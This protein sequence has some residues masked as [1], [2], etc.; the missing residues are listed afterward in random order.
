[1]SFEKGDVMENN[2]ICK[3]MNMSMGEQTTSWE[4]PVVFAARCWMFKVSILFYSILSSPI[5]SYSMP[6][7]LSDD[8]ICLIDWH[9]VFPVR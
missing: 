2:G 4:D 8:D 5:L 3:T 6:E 9:P 7:C 1:M